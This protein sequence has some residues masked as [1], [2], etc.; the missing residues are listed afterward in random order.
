ME[1]RL[2]AHG[3]LARAMTQFDQREVQLMKALDDR[4]DPAEV[5]QIAED[6]GAI[7]VRLRAFHVAH[8]RLLTDEHE[9]AACQ[10]DLDQM[11]ARFAQTGGRTKTHLEQNQMV[12]RVAQP[13]ART[14]TYPEPAANAGQDLM[15][16][17]G[18]DIAFSIASSRRSSTSTTSSKA[19]AAAA[20]KK[21][22]LLAEASAL[23]AQQWLDEEEMELRRRRDTEEAERRRRRDQQR[24][25]LEDEERQIQQRREAEE[26]QLRQRRETLR[27][28]TGIS[29][30]A[31]EEEAW[32]NAEHEGDPMTVRPS[33]RGAPVVSGSLLTRDQ[34]ANQESNLVN[35]PS[36]QRYPEPNG[37]LLT[38]EKRASIVSWAD[39]VET[40][41]PPDAADM[42]R[43][44]FQLSR[45][46]P[47]A[48]EWVEK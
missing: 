34:L 36:E 35:K 41:V 38:Q 7:I 23:K 4:A 32:A 15:A 11:V 29:K 10:R 27:L 47:L 1:E 16:K 39:K 21:A 33:D 13:E 42:R 44:L 43:S 8:F 40:G 30:A 3:D 45:L 31:A 48:G 37:A 26:L 20:A 19:E 2:K 22:I 6:L 24:Q 9:R 17:A 12:E 18:S 14:K 28:Q 46:N 25:K 5:H